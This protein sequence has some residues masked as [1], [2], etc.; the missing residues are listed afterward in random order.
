VSCRY[1]IGKMNRQFI[2]RACTLQ[3]GAVG[4]LFF[5][6]ALC[7]NASLAPIDARLGVH[8]NTTFNET[9]YYN[10]PDV[11]IESI[12][13]KFHLGSYCEKFI[14]RHGKWARAIGLR[15]DS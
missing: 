12:L 13:L 10:T 14:L 7:V 9:A 8:D 4:M 11:S 1:D 15:L 6:A 2:L 3:S 5:L